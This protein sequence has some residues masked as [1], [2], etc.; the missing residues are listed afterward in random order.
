M[1]LYE[2]IYKNGKYYNPANKHY[3][4][5][6]T[7]SCD[8]CQRED[9]EVCIGWKDNDLCLDCVSKLKKNTKPKT[10]KK[11]SIK[12]KGSVKKRMMQKQYKSRM[13]QRQFN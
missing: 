11:K 5:K 7:V 8:K 12:K 2:S 1:S 6:G 9:L 3:D 10:E 13:K 4:G